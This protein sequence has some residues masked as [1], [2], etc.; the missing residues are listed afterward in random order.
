[1]SEPYWRR[2]AKGS[3]DKEAITSPRDEERFLLAFLLGAR[4]GSGFSTLEWRLW[5]AAVSR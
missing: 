2:L 3:T 4:R 1:M 5:E